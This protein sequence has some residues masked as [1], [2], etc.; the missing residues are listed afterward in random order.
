MAAGSILVS[1]LMNTGSF[2]TDTDRAAKHAQK[3][4]KDIERAFKNV[5]GVIAGGIAGFGVAKLFGKFVQESREA[6]EEQ[7]QLAAVLRSTG[8]AAGYSRDQLNAMAE[9]MAKASTFG[10]GDINKA[11]TRLLAYTGIVGKQFPEAMQATIDMAAR[12]GMSVEQSA[13]TIGKA[14]DIPSKGL[15]ALSKQGFRFTEDQEKMVKA[16]EKTGRVGEAQAI[17][18]DALKSA[19]GGAAQ[20]SRDTFGGALVALQEQLNDLMTGGDGSL[21]GTAKAVNDLTDVLGSA[22]TKA[23]F[24][25]MTGLIADTISVLVKATTEFLNFGRF[26][27]EYV[28]EAVHGSAEPLDRLDA[29]IAEV[30]GTVAYLENEL[31]RPKKFFVSSE[32]VEQLKKD[33]DAARAS[34]AALQAQRPGLVAD[35]LR[36]QTTAAVPTPSAPRRA[37]VVVSDDGKKPKLTEAD[38]YL[39]NLQKQLEKTRD[40]SVYEQLLTDIQM[41]R[42]GKVSAGQQRELEGIAK[43]IDAARAL[44]TQEED[45]AKAREAAADLA[46]R[47]QESRL[48]ETKSLIDGNQALRDEIDLIGADAEKREEL[49]KARIAAT[50]ALREESLAMAR[51]AGATAE[52]VSSLEQQIALLR[53]RSDL[54]GKKGVAERLEEDAKRFEEITKR[55]RENVQDSLGDS[56]YEA[57]NGNFKNIGQA[58]TQMLQRMV[59]ESLAAD[60]MGKLFGSGK[61]GGSTGLVGDVFGAVG[62]FFGFGGARAGGGDVL[63]DRSYLVGE[64]GPERFVPRTAGTILPAQK[65]AAGNSIHFTLHQSFAPGTDRRTVLQAAADAQMALQRGARNL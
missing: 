28:A 27:G 48:A 2:T 35:A 34:L 26:V 56:I 55:M 9:Q 15:T 63:P 45:A 20:A 18:L 51:N 54:I 24:A 23:A 40:L 4:A 6:Q 59:A 46:R 19:Y 53:Q 30:A 14:L 38:R 49:E 50:I 1:L 31:K 16:L 39:Q 33:L 13:E 64:D 22:E 3:R 32:G 8:E 43:Q 7:A 65:A 5:G 58:F 12:L 29:K 37:P 44:K 10:A 36:G 17:V 21:N 52:E 61:K 41:G 57:M 11:Q 42:L 47:A 62:S 25:T 60:V